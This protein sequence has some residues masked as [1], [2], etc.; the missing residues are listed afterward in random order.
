[1]NK[2]IEK[3]KKVLEE[4]KSEL[5]DKFDVNEIGLFGSYARGDQNKNSDLDVLVE[6]GEIPGLFKFVH[7]ED[8][9]SA[10]L[11]VKV[12]LVRK[13]AIRKELKDTILGEAI[14]I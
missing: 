14:F 7:L 3:L 6:F 13:S 4:H 8:Y 1:M 9:L 2:K 12:D 11:G 5:N 10:L